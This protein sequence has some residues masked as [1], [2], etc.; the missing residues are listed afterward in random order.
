MRWGRCLYGAVL[1]ATMT[2]L[3]ALA[4]PRPEDGSPGPTAPEAQRA[5]PLRL[6]LM[7]PSGLVDVPTSFSC[8]ESGEEAR[9]L[10]S[11]IEL[12]A[13]TLPLT[14]RLTLHAFSRWGCTRTDAVAA[15]ATYRVELGS[16]MA[17]VLAAGVAGFP[18]AQDAGWLFRPSLRADLQWTTKDKQL[19]SVGVDATQILKS[20]VKAGVQRRVGLS[21]GGSF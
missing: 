15:G 21:V 11:H 14:R 3:P 17:I 19:R 5:L 13:A 18:H 12:S 10:S 9:Q 20:A 8:R 16:K 1:A 2:S 4:Q 6:S 7:D